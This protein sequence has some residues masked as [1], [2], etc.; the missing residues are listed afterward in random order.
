M[1]SAR[2]ISY[3][4]ICLPEVCV[5][6][7]NIAQK[8]ASRDLDQAVFLDEFLAHSALSA[9]GRSVN[10]HLERFG[11][12]GDTNIGQRR[13]NSGGGGGGG[14]AVRGLG[15]SAIRAKNIASCQKKYHV[16]GSNAPFQ[17]ITRRNLR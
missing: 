4:R 8:V 16:E 5:A 9:P 3:S 13:S 7:G 1:N 17:A 12:L 11:V 10:S 15:F 2:R 6:F 14:P